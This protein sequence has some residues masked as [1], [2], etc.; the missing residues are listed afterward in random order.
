MSSALAWRSKWL[1][2]SSNDRHK[3]TCTSRCVSGGVQLP[4]FLFKWIPMWALVLKAKAQWQVHSKHSAPQDW[5]L[6]IGLSIKSLGCERLSPIP[7]RPKGRPYKR[8]R[9][10]LGGK[11]GEM[12]SWTPQTP[13]KRHTKWNSAAIRRQDMLSIH[14]L[15]A[16]IHWMAGVL[17][18]WARI[19]SCYISPFSK[20]HVQKLLHIRKR[21]WGEGGQYSGK[22]MVCN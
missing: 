5:T 12:R 9:G 19:E 10:C 11:T 14:S 6:P 15:P 4:A 2:R 20:Q 1:K 13:P 18:L 8:S 22:V 16:R 7:H 3:D 21:R 17:D